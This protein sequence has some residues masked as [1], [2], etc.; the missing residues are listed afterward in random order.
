M[1]RQ[2]ARLWHDGK[3]HKDFWKLIDDE[4]GYLGKSWR[5]HWQIYKG[6]K[7]LW[8]KLPPNFLLSTGR[9]YNLS[10]RFY[11][12]VK[13]E[14]F[15][16]NGFLKSYID[17]SKALYNFCKVGKH[18]FASYGAEVYCTENCYSWKEVKTVSSHT[19]DT[20]TYLGNYNER[21][22]IITNNAL[23]VY[24]IRTDYIKELDMPN[25][26]YISEHIGDKSYESKFCVMNETLIVATGEKNPYG[27][28]DSEGLL[29]FK[30]DELVRHFYSFVTAPGFGKG[31]NSWVDCVASD[32]KVAYL[33][34]VVNLF[35]I[36][37][38]LEEGYKSSDGITWEKFAS[39]LTGP[40]FF[41]NGNLYNTSTILTTQSP[42]IYKYF[43]GE[44]LRIENNVNAY[45]EFVGGDAMQ[46]NTFSA[47]GYI[48][49][50]IKDDDGNI[51]F[52]RFKDYDSGESEIV[53]NHG[54]TNGIYIE[55]WED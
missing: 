38:N 8:E 17:E 6:N 46:K 3:D 49:G 15:T 39:P 25:F 5:M 29:V 33:S 27:M 31:H 2:S 14:K 18:L 26:S 45:F 55:S 43:D 12:S 48:Y 36:E 30:N 35:G 13:G 40:L 9:Y 51:C 1:G 50:N 53:L 10:G 16:D 20:V 28:R 19:G 7:L 24:D 21:L 47:K 52:A 11:D 41:L 34:G 54:I 4:E 22:L 42:I 23:F 44:F 32:G 37:T